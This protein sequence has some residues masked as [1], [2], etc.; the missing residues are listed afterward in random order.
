MKKEVI[1]YIKT[2]MME[3]PFKKNIVAYGWEFN[4]QTTIYASVI[5]YLFEQLVIID[6]IAPI[7]NE[8]RDGRIK[9]KKY[10]VVHDTGDT[11]DY[12]NAQ[13][14]SNVVKTENNEGNPYHA[15]FQYVVGEDGIYH[16][17]PDNEIAYHAGDSTKFD[18]KLYDTSVKGSTN[19][20]VTIE[21]D[22]YYYING[23]KTKIIAPTLD[24]KMMKTEDINDMGVLCKLIDGTYYIG[25]TYV[26][27]TYHKVANRGGNNNGIGIEI[28]VSEKSDILR[29]FQ[30][31][32]KLCAFLLDVYNLS[33]YDI[34]QHHYFSGKDCPM[35]L[36]NNKL[37]D[38]FIHLVDVEL[39]MRKFAKEGYQFKLIPLSTNVKENGRIIDLK[40]KIKY[41]IL[42]TFQGEKTLLDYNE[43]VSN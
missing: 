20:N 43:N 33:V 36:R 40:Q 28:S 4:Y 27:S 23:K 6:N 19:G 41:Q 12:R 1:E 11:K 25:E 13:F 22:G 21:S 5:P 17:I 9:E 31:A 15:S 16:N 35:T 42:I 24:K 18:Y 10:I 14:W 37:W 30:L 8:N 29:N 38:Y 39:H 7:T 32:S 26:N 3:K 2:L 34:K